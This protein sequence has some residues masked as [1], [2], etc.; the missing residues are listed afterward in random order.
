MQ[1][2][3]TVCHRIEV[4]LPHMDETNEAAHRSFF[5]ENAFPWHL[6]NDNIR[7]AFCLT[8]DDLKRNRVVAMNK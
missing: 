5:F 4:V 3:L 7:Q 8:G 6:T 2:D 1:F